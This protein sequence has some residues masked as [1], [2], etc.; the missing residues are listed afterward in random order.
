MLRAFNNIG[1]F[2]YAIHSKHY[3]PV[4]L[5]DHGYHSHIKDITVAIEID[6]GLLVLQNS[7]HH[8]LVIIERCPGWQMTS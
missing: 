1:A 2:H 8:T 5:F 7:P 3:Q 4:A 6:L